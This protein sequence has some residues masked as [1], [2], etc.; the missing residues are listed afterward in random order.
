MKKTAM[1]AVMLCLSAGTSLPVLADEPCNMVLCMWGKVSGSGSE[2]C[3]DQI[4]KFFKKQV[5]KKGAF[6]PDKTADARKDMLMQ[7]CPS[8][9]AP[10]QFINDI[11]SKFGRVKG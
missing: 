2:G 6:R 4:K 11:I 1:A 8:A 3:N 7:E 9:M 5:T 10:A